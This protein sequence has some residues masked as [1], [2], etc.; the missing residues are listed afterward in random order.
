MPETVIADAPALSVCEPEATTYSG[1][2]DPS[3]ALIGCVVPPTTTEDPPDSREYVVP[4][5]V[6]GAPPAERVCEPMT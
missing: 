5:T 3:K 2:L 1:V 4:E 6:I